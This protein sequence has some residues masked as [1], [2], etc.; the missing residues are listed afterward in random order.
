MKKDANEILDE[1]NKKFEKQEKAVSD[2]THAQLIDAV[3][4]VIKQYSLDVNF[5]QPD[6]NQEVDGII[7]INNEKGE[8][9]GMAINK[10][11]QTVADKNSQVVNAEPDV[12]KDI[13]SDAANKVGE[14]DV[15]QNSEDVNAGCGE[16]KNLEDAVNDNCDD[17]SCVNNNADTNCEGQPQDNCA[18]T[19][20]EGNAQDNDD[21]DPDDNDPDDDDKNDVDDKDTNNLEEMSKADKKT[22]EATICTLKQ[23]IIK[24]KAELKVAEPYKALYE[25]SL[26]TIKDLETYKEEAELDKLRV[27]KTNYAKTCNFDALEDEDK[28]VVQSKIDDYNFSL[29]DFKAFMADVLKKYSRK[30][31][32]SSMQ[33]ILSYF[34]T[35]DDSKKADDVIAMPSDK[36][37]ADRVLDKY[38]DAI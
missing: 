22:Y 37:M 34:S 17:T 26:K 6:I 24:L 31:V 4:E 5:N 2:I 8:G 10:E 16:N 29:Y 18:N 13:Q 27:N 3:K 32:Y 30:Q 28:E 7:N 15:Q 19:G 1:Y 35:E 20:M 33:Q 38:S 36:N 9:E 21:N 14:P 25:E 12:Q 23:N 11:D